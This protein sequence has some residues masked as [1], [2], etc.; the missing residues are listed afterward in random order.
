MASVA[1]HRGNI[2]PQL[3][4]EEHEGD[5]NAKK[6]SLGTAKNFDG[7][8]PGNT[9]AEDDPTRVIIDRNRRLY[10]NTVH[11][12]YW[13]YHLN[14][15]T[16]QTDTQIQA[17]P[18]ANYSI[19]ITD[20]IFSSGAATA[21]NIFFEEGSTTVLGPFYLEAIAGRGLTINLTTPKQIT[22]NTA[23]TYTTSQSTAQNIDILGYISRVT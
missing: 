14:T 9:T 16:A 22:A 4:L 13:S 17:A 21:I 18:G 3:D 7:T 6:V 19:F 20:I 1:N 2:Q 12:Q 15:S 5:L 23:V 11:P 8:D 10:V